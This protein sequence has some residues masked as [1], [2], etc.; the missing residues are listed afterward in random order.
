[1]TSGV[2]R[3]LIGGGGGGDIHIFVC[4]ASVNDYRQFLADILR[5]EN[6]ALHNSPIRVIFIDLLFSFSG[7][8]EPRVEIFMLKIVC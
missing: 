7:E 3:A 1:M 8:M 4:Y 2:T 6:Q 5:H